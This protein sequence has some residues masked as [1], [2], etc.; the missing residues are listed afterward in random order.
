MLVSEM[1]R[2]E[3]EEL[4]ARQSLGRL[5]CAHENQ[6]YI[7]PIY[8]A[9]E[10]GRLYGFST[11]GQ[12]IDWIRRNPLVCIEV[13]EIIGATEWAS[14]VVQGRYEEFPDT[15]EYAEPRRK[16]QAQLEKATSLWWQTAIAVTQTRKRVDRDMTVFF[17]IHI[18]EISGRHG[19]PDPAEHR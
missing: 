9:S 7:V 15:S 5:A 3:C 11:M 18:E 14:V 19:W 2:K 16:A 4:L 13:D 6:P 8:F 10:P 1:N 17:C 12:K